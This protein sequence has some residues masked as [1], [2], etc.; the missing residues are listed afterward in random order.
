MHKVGLQGLMRDFILFC[1]AFLGRGRVCVKLCHFN[2]NS[3]GIK[4]LLDIFEFLNNLL[5]IENRPLVL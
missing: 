4:V 5:N 3:L 2:S 1:M